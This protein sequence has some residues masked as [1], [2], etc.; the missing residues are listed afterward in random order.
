MQQC[1][2]LTTPS[3]MPKPES[4][5]DNLSEL[6]GEGTNTYNFELVSC[7]RAKGRNINLSANVC[8]NTHMLSEEEKQYWNHFIDKV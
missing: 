2:A 6:F 7:K 8:V 1:L 3:T 5:P 4:T